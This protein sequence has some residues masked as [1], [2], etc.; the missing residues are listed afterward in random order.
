MSDLPNRIADFITAH[1]KILI[2]VLLLTTAGFAVGVPMV[3][4]DSEVEQF[5]S[6]SE[7]TEAQDYINENFGVEMDDDEDEFQQ[8]AVQAAYRADEGENALSQDA[9]VATLE[10]QKQLLESESVGETLDRRSPFQSVAG[11]IDVEGEGQLNQ[12]PQTIENKTSQIENRIEYIEEDLSEE[13]LEEKLQ[14]LSNDRDPRYLSLLPEAYEPGSVEAEAQLVVIAQSTGSPSFGNVQEF[15]TVTDAQLDIRDIANNREETY[16]LFGPGILADEIERSLGD[17]FIIVGPLALLFVVVALSVA[18]RDIVDILLGMFGVV[19]VLIWMFGFMGFADIPFN[20]LLISV[21]V[22]LIGLSIDYAIHVFMRH[23]EKRGESDADVRRSMTLALAGVGVALVWVTVTAAIGFLANLASPIGP[24]QDFGIVAT[25]GVVSALLVFGILT[26]ALKIEIDGLLERFGFNREKRAFGTGGSI[27]SGMLSVGARLARRVPFTV[28]IIALLITAGGVYGAT[29]VDTSFQEEDFLADSPP[30]WTQNLPEPFALGTYQAKADLSYIQETFLT[31]GSDIDFLIQGETTANETL[32]WISEGQESLNEQDTVI[33]EPATGEADITSPLTVMQQ[34]RADG[35]NETFNDLY[36]ESTDNDIPVRNIEELYG[37]LLDNPETAASGADV[38]YRTEEGEYEAL[39][40]TVEVEGDADIG[41]VT[42]E[43]R[44]VASELEEIS[45]GNLQVQATG[46]P[47]IFSDVEADLL[48]TVLQGLVLTLIAVFVFMIVGY[49]FAG[50]TASL[51]VIT[52]LPVVLSVMWILG[53]MWVLDIPF[54]VLTGTITSLTIGLGIAYSIHISARYQLELERQNTVWDALYTT[55]T[56]TGGAL[57][58][59]AATTVGAFGTLSFAI[60][61]VLRQFGIITGLTIIY[62]FLASVLVLPS[63]L[64][65][66][67]RYVGSPPGS[68]SSSVSDGPSDPGVSAEAPQPEDK[69]T[70]AEQ[71]VDIPHK[72]DI[73]LDDSA[74][75]EPVETSH[76]RQQTDVTVIM[77][78]DSRD[79]EDSSDTIEPSPAEGDDETDENR[80]RKYQDVTIIRG[81]RQG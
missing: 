77:E 35:E 49:Y 20:Q 38:I 11:L 62:A 12:P 50:N 76:Q 44:G 13:E 71:I 26:P 78:P 6:E 48:S 60:F 57:V 9:L 65:L 32:Q 75:V 45:D 43:M 1:S 10:F 37:L 22:L 67:T 5:E 80:N 81:E 17:S 68:S 18:Y 69:G 4:Q 41:E 28:V 73:Q 21:P 74:V 56:G 52:L 16:A 29:Q 3:E 63:L 2:V 51:G 33:I 53:S 42:E 64:V 59:S 7:A 66:W 15:S 25:F 46:E 8:S 54:N 31:E 79:I 40:M 34:T 39:R 19:A 23:R 61:P 55:V 30:E 36:N 72:D 70:P 24:L 47:I 27:F 58:G 14:T